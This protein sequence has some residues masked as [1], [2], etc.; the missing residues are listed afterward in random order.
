MHRIGSAD[1]HAQIQQMGAIYSSAQVTLIAAAG[2]DPTHGLPGITKERD[3]SA[4]ARYM[5]GYSQN[6]SECW[7]PIA[8]AILDYVWTSRAWAFQEGYLPKRRMYFT[9]IGAVFMC[10]AGEYSD[11]G[12]SFSLYLR[13]SVSEP[14]AV[15]E[16]SGIFN[17]ATSTLTTHAGRALNFESDALHATAG[18]LNSLMKMVDPIGHI[19]GVPFTIPSQAEES[20]FALLWSHRK[21]GCRRPGFSSCSPIG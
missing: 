21:P 16:R 10:N 2:K 7:I 11:H 13:G 18:V 15:N 1:R 5:Q 20:R 9:D 17:Q 4:C 12:L 8:F 6:E 3:R 14:V 19:W